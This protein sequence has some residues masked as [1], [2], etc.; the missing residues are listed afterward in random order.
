MYNV[1]RLFLDNIVSSVS[2]LQSAFDGQIAAI[3]DSVNKWA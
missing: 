1:I 3:E 2:N